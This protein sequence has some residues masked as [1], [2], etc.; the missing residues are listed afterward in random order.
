[1]W[2]VQTSDLVH[3]AASLSSSGQLSWSFFPLFDFFGF[4]FLTHIHRHTPMNGC[5]K[6]LHC[7]SYWFLCFGCWALRDLKTKEPVVFLS[8]LPQSICQSARSI[9]SVPERIHLRSRY[10]SP[11][12]H[13]TS[14][15]SKTKSQILKD[16]LFFFPL[17]TRNPFF[18]HP[19]EL[20][21]I[22]LQSLLYY[23]ICLF[24]PK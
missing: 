21:V 9:E 11:T 13:W 16:S 3:V 4:F 6:Q 5:F 7:C 18:R 15:Q 14:H 20:T 23:F 24:R 8:K 22:Q 2:G 19:T 1:M 10:T 17:K 12:L